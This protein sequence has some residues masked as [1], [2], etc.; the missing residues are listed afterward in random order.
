MSYLPIGQAAKTEHWSIY[1]ST[2]A[3][4]SLARREY[5]FRAWTS[6]DYQEARF[7]IFGCGPFFKDDPLLTMQQDF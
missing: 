6:K 1:A 7:Y 2:R 4:P 3:R 5:G